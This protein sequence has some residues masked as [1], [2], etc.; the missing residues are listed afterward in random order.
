MGLEISISRDQLPETDEDE[1]YWADLIGLRVET[2]DGRLLGVVDH[3]MET[4][5]NDVLVVAGD[6]QC[7]VPFLWETVVK[8][9][10]LSERLVVVDWDPDL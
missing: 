2:I 7:L 8:R 10:S 1:F 6:T 9:I 4:G 3:L 5:S